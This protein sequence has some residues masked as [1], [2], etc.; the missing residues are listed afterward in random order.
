MKY[1]NSIYHVG[2]VKERV[3][4]PLQVKCRMQTPWI[5]EGKKTP[6]NEEGKKTPWIEEGKK[7]P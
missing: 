1:T 4:L 5:E 7:T 2:R 6:W 3:P